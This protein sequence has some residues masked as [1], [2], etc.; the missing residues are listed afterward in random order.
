MPND[1]SFEVIPEAKPFHLPNKG[2]KVLLIHGFTA[3]PTE[4]RPVGEFLHEAGYEVHSVLLA[5]HG[6]SPKDLQTKKWSDWWLSAKTAF[7]QIKNCEI[8]IGFSMGALLAARLAVEYKSQVKALVLLSPYLKV[9][10]QIISCFSFL[11][12]LIALF[13][14][15]IQKGSDAK[16]FFQE[17]N[18]VSYTSYPV[19]A[20]HQTFKLINYTKK[21]VI[22]YLSIPTLIIQGEQD[23]RVDPNGYRYFLKHMK[24]N[25]VEVEL[26]PQ[27]K[28]ILTVGPNQKQLK[29]ALLEFLTKYLNEK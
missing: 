14:P 27:S 22:P 16:P 1:T 8:I 19:V 18:L 11:F 20:A 6:T 17:H 24:T 4:M 29:E 25:N 9:K 2:K 15:Y 26:L 12:P 5:G 13:K 10:P 7:E 23:D 28:H 3:S 21:N